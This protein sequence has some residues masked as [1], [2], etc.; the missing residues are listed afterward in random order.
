MSGG[1][2]ERASRIE[3]GSN[4]RWTLHIAP[5]GDAAVR[6]TLPATED[7]AA[8]GAVCTAGGVRLAQ[9]V[10][11]TVPGPAA[12]VPVTATLSVE[13]AVSDGTFPVRVAF[14]A[15]VTGFR[16]SDLTA[17]QVGGDT[18]AVTALAETQAGHAWTARVASAGA[19]RMW[20]RAG[21]VE[22]VAGGESEPALLVVDVDADGNVAA[23]T[24]PAVL[25]AAVTPPEDGFWDG[26]DPLEATLRFS[27]PVTVDSS[28]GTPT[29]RLVV[30]GSALTAGYLGVEGEAVRFGGTILAGHSAEAVALVADSLALNGAA[31]AGS[32]GA[33]ADLAH[34]AA[35]HSAGT[36]PAPAA[37][38]AAVS[39]PASHGG[40]GQALQVSILFSAPVDLTRDGIAIEGGALDGFGVA[41]KSRMRWTVVVAPASDAPVTIALAAAET[42][43]SAGAI[44]T[45]DGMP[46]AAGVSAT[47]PGPAVMADPDALTALT[48]ARR[49]RG[50]WWRTRTRTT[51]NGACRARCGLRPGSAGAG[52][53]SRSVR[54][55]AR[56]RAR[57]SG[58]GG[59][60]MRA[61]LRPA[62]SSRRRGAFRASSATGCRCSA[63]ASP[64][65]RMSGSGFR[66]VRATTASAGG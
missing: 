12:A 58:C 39:A 9:A 61:G 25:A 60:A 23:V 52:S 7:C 19:G 65:R 2:I 53:R 42:C 36:R 22:T 30:D 20:V 45:V 26:G 1:T 3:A 11:A 51:R 57:R 33:A 10:E 24:R 28:R 50:C 55:W 38:T 21:S 64:A 34:P 56:R 17:G 47:V 63:T 35:A 41:D 31:I 29:V 15:A 46:L 48:A 18:G 44:C 49:R 6:V 4:A 8:S 27:E 14:S 5:D 40:A 43:D 62:A 32:G 59:R 54:R 13:G 16:D 37:L 66:T